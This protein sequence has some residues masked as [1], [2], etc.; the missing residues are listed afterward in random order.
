MEKSI[1]LDLYE[2]V[3]MFVR[4]VG[5]CSS[6]LKATRIFASPPRFLI[7]NNTHKGFFEH[8][9]FL[10]LREALPEYLRGFA[11]FGYKTGWRSSEIANLTWRQVDIDQ[12]IVRLESRRDQEQRRPNR[13]P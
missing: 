3:S 13:L 4:V 2:Q 12:G 9:E 7:E 8:H 5:S 6:V 1:A 11:T 10:A